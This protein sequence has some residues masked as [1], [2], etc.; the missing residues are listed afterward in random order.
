MYE[1][2]TWAN[3]ELSDWRAEPVLVVKDPKDVW[4]EQRLTFSYSHVHEDMPGAEIVE[5]IQ[6]L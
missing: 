2:T 5:L 3:G 6:W 1:Y 4:A